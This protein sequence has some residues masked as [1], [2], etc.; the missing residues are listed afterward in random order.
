MATLKFLSANST[1]RSSWSQFA[2]T[3]FS[4]DYGPYCPISSPD[5]GSYFHALLIP[6]LF[7]HMLGILD[8][9]VLETLDSVNSL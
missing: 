9:M 3:I 7:H 2:L 6:V 4:L 8:D 5:C 1:S